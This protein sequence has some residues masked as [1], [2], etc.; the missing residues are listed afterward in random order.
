LNN[1]RGKLSAIVFAEYPVAQT[2]MASAGQAF[3]A[4]FASQCHYL[5]SFRLNLKYSHYL[6]LRNPSVMNYITAHGGIALLRHS[7]SSDDPMARFGEQP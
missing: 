7:P 6:Y 5:A 3:F 1:V 2:T 4:V